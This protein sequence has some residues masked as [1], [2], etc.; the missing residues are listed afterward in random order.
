MTEQS[1]RNIG[2]EFEEVSETP[3]ERIVTRLKVTGHVRGGDGRMYEMV[4]ELSTNTIRKEPPGGSERK[5]N[6]S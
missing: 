5:D 1:P 3:T 6:A 4:E 2:T